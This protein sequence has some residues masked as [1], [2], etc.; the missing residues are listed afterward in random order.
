MQTQLSENDWGC[1]ERASNAV[2]AA[3]SMLSCTGMLLHVSG[4]LRFGK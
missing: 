4:A 2:L 1:M 3:L